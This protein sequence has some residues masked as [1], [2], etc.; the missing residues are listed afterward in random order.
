MLLSRHDRAY[1]PYFSRT[2][3]EC[4]AKANAIAAASSEEKAVVAAESVNKFRTSG[5][6]FLPY[7]QSLVRNL[8]FPAGNK[9]AEKKP[10]KAPVVSAEAIDD[11][12]TPTQVEEL[13]AALKAYPASMDKNERWTSIA[14]AV[15]GKNK[16]QCVAKFKLIR[17]G[18]FSCFL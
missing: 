11:V 4:I 15:P 17:Q 14:V 2:Q 16:K 1:F 12:W 3:E 8:L 13:Q 6:Y 9:S 7:W 5:M 18:R 10:S